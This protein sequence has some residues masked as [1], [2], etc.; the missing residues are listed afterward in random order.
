MSTKTAL[1]AALRGR[2]RCRGKLGSVAARPAAVA[3]ARALAILRFVDLERAAVEVG[4]VQRL[5][6][7]GCV[8]VRHLHETEA[9]RA[10]RVAI[11]DQGDLLDR[12][13]RCF[14]ST[15]PSRK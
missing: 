7:T 6:G 10:T 8:G 4:A 14:P 9:A 13:A 3:T 2:E 1:T 12:S 5:H 15:E 11:G